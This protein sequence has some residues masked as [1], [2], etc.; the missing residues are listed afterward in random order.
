MKKDVVETT[1]QNQT[2]ERRRLKQRLKRSMIEEASSNQI[3]WLEFIFGIHNVNKRMG[4]AGSRSYS[5]LNL[6]SYSLPALCSSDSNQVTG[7]FTPPRI[8]CNVST[9][10]AFSNSSVLVLLSSFFNSWADSRA[11]DIKQSSAA[12]HRSHR[13]VSVMLLGLFKSLQRVP[14]SQLRRCAWL[15]LHGI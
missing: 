12:V 14:N 4:K 11:D 8:S 7:W 6:A 2:A 15:F 10:L 9:I 5:L 1:S 13:A 3:G